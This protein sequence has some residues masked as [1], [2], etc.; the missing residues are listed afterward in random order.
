MRSTVIKFIFFVITTCTIA[1][2]Q[3]LVDLRKPLNPETFKLWD[4]YIRKYAPSDSALKVVSH[5]ASRHY[6]VNS[7]IVARETYLYFQPLFPNHKVDFEYE[8]QRMEEL[9]IAVA[10]TLEQK[11]LYEKFINQTAPAEKAYVGVQRLAEDYINRKDWDS[12]LIVFKY[13]MPLFP[14]M[15]K[16]FSGIISCLSAPEEAISLNNMGKAINTQLDEW[17]PTPVPGGM[18][19]FFTASNRR[20]GYGGHDIWFSEYKDSAWQKAVNLGNGINSKRN[21]TVDNVSADGTALY[22]SGDFEGTLGKFDIYYLQKNKTG[23]NALK[24]LPYPINSKYLD[25]GAGESPDGKAIIFASDRPGGVGDYHPYGELFHGDQEG[26]I[27]FYVCL[28]TD[29]GWSDPI[30]LGKTINTPYAERS[31]YLHPDGKTLYFSSDGHSSLGRTDM[32]KSVRLRDD[33]WTEWSEPVNLGKELNTSSSD[34]G[35]IVSANGDSAFFAA[36]N[37]SEGNGGW[38]IYTTSV[39]KENKPQTTIILKGKVTDRKGKALEALIKWEDL[40]TG[41][42]IGTLRTDPN[43]GEYFI[44]LTPGRNYGYYA[45][46]EKYYPNSSNIDL[47]SNITKKEYK[48]NIVLTSIRESGSDNRSIRINNLFF[49]F[50]DYSLKPESYPELNRLAKILNENSKLK[51]II[52]GHTDSIGTNS[53]NLSLSTKRANSV[54]QFLLK[55][56]I[57]EKRIKTIGHGSNIP[58]RANDTEE[59]R[60]TNRRV[61]I[62]FKGK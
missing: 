11:P 20:G 46:K 62:N 27:D 53:Y 5:I 10:P 36:R 21:E 39:K 15:K 48:R 23:W 18:L 44:S 19:L 47:K 30:N 14:D 42:N 24:H 59:N 4:E 12:A 43:T 13:F 50:N 49:D 61:E 17:D 26:N 31:P 28:K 3:T 38:D 6:S 32:F 40:E 29:S 25:E 22:L 33:S 16:R 9:L 35:Y 34:W 1:L 37:R 2:S 51:I 41:K 54:K 52:K 60:Q 7:Y 57:S 56:N 55:N 45:E 58:I 8:I